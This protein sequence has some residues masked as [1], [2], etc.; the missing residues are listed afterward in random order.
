M[1][2]PVS[3][4]DWPTA[5]NKTAKYIGRHWPEG[6]LKLN[7]SREITAKL[8]GY[9]SVHDVQKELLSN[10]QKTFSIQEMAKSMTLRGLVY[11]G[12]HPESSSALFR[13]LP[14]KNLSVWERTREA[15]EQ[16]MLES[17]RD[18]QGYIVLDEFHEIANYQ[19]PEHLVTLFD[20]L[21]IPLF[22]YAVTKHGTIYQRHY[23]ESLIYDFDL[24]G[25]ELLGIDFK[26]SAIDFL[27]QYILPLAW[28]K[29]EDAVREPRYGDRIDWHLPYMNVLEP[30]KNNRFA[31]FHEGLM[32]YFPVSVDEKGLPNL[33]KKIYLNEQIPCSENLKDIEVD[34]RQDFI[35]PRF[36]HIDGTGH[37]LDQGERLLV[38]GQEYIRANNLSG[39]TK[40]LNSFWV[41]DWWWPPMDD[42][43]P[44]IK[45]D[46][47]AKGIELEHEKIHRWAKVVHSHSGRT[48]NNA[49]I[50]TLE[51]A[52]SVFFEGVYVSLDSLKSSGQFDIES[53]DYEDE[54][55]VAE[56]ISDLKES[57][58]SVRAQH[59]ELA[60]HYDDVALGSLY[61]D[62]TGG[63]HPYNCYE[64]DSLFLAFVFGLRFA[65]LFDKRAHDQ[66][67]LAGALLADLLSGKLE[68]SSARE[69]WHSGQALLSHFKKQECAIRKLTE[70]ARHRSSC[71]TKHVSHGRETELTRK[72]SV[73]AIQDLYRLGRKTSMAATPASQLPEDLTEGVRKEIGQVMLHQI[74]EAMG[75]AFK[76]K[77]GD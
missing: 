69:A 21:S 46:T 26:G 10:D 43:S 67:T 4:A 57:G 53:G 50:E 66:S 36:E 49:S 24:D 9:H 41:Q 13:N 3:Q 34:R 2:I 12:L 77:E 22:E 47:L 60:K 54:D 48:I 63:R 14:W 59:A 25:D 33:L 42:F 1:R 52:I 61:Q 71:D 39:Y 51:S 74:S 58:E 29:I 15:A 37:P 17:Q 35:S 20:E 62:Y 40:L 18:R 23:L 44:T 32:A 73:E 72:S 6:Q 7:K 31:I 38:D 5:F 56:K 45:P 30:L 70:Y 68:F 65:D 75:G 76:R 19:S 27:K 55:E 28:R 8:F 16:R 11:F 64:R